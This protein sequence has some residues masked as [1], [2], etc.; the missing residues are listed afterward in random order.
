MLT[1]DESYPPVLLAYKAK[2]LRLET[3]NWAL[4]AKHEEFELSLD[5][6]ARKYLVRPF[7][8]L[9]NPIC[10]LM[11][12]YASFVYGLIYGSL[13][14]IPIIFEERR[15]WT[16]VQGSLPF[17][18]LLLGAVFGLGASSFN[19]KPYVKAINAN[20]GK[21]VPEARLFPM[22]FGG[23]FLSAGLFIL[24]WTGTLSV[25]WVVPCI[26]I[27]FIGIG[28]FPIFQSST[29]YVCCTGL[30]PL[31]TGRLTYPK[32]IIDA[33]LPVAASA[34]ATVTFM[35]SLFAAVFSIFMVSYQFQFAIY[36]DALTVREGTYVGLVR[37]SVGSL[38]SRIRLGSLTTSTILI[39]RLRQA[40]K[41]SWCEVEVLRRIALDANEDV[42]KTNTNSWHLSINHSLKVNS[43]KC[44]NACLHHAFRRNI[45]TCM[46]NLTEVA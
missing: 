28:F 16:P 41:G 36:A 29:N 14:A 23:T 3:G 30:R 11:S 15:G 32:Q 1:V 6:I 12:F 8:L 43:L 18:A 19:Q 9:V 24:A 10:F 22:M 2:R 5:V 20:G 37:G 17:L 7:K 4:H 39:L 38:A 13:A 21:P 44:Y 25:I 31:N 27:L 33:F 42:E 40:V 45:I 35:R 34:I 26:G 46:K